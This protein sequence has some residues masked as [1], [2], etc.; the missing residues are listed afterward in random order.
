VG[1]PYSTDASKFASIGIPSVVFGPGSIA[2]AHSLEEFVEV[3]QVEAYA[4]II[5]RL[6]GDE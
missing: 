6:I 2:Q 5:E 4:S 1:V 3:E